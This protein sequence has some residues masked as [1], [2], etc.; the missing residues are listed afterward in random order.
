MGLD[1]TL[2]GEE[3]GGSPSNIG[4]TFP[5]RGGEIGPREWLFLWAGRSSRGEVGIL[6][7][8]HGARLKK[9]NGVRAFGSGVELWEVSE[10]VGLVN[11]AGVV[12]Q[13]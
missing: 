13:G 5:E 2:W 3:N 8:R 11:Q 1:G 10:E 12:D 6:N 4:V 7:G 9:K